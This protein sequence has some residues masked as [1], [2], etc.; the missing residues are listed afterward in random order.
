MALATS[1][2]MGISQQIGQYA[3]R[4]ATKRLYKAIPWIGA[5]VAVVTVGQTMRRKG[6]FRGALDVLLDFTPVVGTVKNLAEAGRG[7][8]FIPDR[9]LYQSP[10]APRA[11]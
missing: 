8:D 10:P 6:M 4:K 11:I 7:R 3:T 5:A 9:R 2:A 1:K